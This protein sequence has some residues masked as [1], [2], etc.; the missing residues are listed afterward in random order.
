MSYCSGSHAQ[1]CSQDQSPDQSLARARIEVVERPAR[2][3]MERRAHLAEKTRRHRQERRRRMRSHL[4]E[5]GA[6]DAQ[7]SLMLPLLETEAI[8]L[9]VNYSWQTLFPDT[10]TVEGVLESEPEGEDA[11]DCDTGPTGW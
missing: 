6:M 8:A 7:A 1:E 4:P 10:A 11:A 3:G 9:E 5:W 2:R